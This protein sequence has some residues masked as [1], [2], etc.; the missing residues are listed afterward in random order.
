MA[1]I[2]V[3]PTMGNP[4]LGFRFAVLFFAGGAVP[5]PI[6]IMFQSVSGLGSRVETTP[7]EEGGQ[8]LYTQSLPNKITH[9][10]LV[11]KRGMV[12]GSPLGIEF[13]AAMSLFTFSP[14]NVLITLMDHTRIP[15]SAWLFIK[16]YPVNWSV[17]DLNAESNEVVVEHME[18]TYQRMQVMR[19]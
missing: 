19:I 17:S 12:T 10:N 1:D 13:N 2:G 11:L 5:N 8:N 18:L 6:D 16:A 3:L 15:I 7:L 14:S 9:D 4:P